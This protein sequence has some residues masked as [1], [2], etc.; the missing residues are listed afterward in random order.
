MLLAPFTLAKTKARNGKWLIKASNEEVHVKHIYLHLTIGLPRGT[1][2]TAG[3]KHIG[4]LPVVVRCGGWLDGASVEA[5]GAGAD[6]GPW[7][8]RY[9]RGE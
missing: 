2:Y 9:Q 4:L 1:S 3:V 7:R 5:A 6:W 8:F